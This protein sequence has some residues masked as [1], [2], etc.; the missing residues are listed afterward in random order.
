M[1]DGKKRKRGDRPRKRPGRHKKSAPVGT[2]TPA[3]TD[4]TARTTEVKDVG[5][6][7]PALDARTLV[8][9]P[10]LDSHGS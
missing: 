2:D 9:D 7:F 5:P 8:G 1:S 10:P 6:E 3:A 4:A